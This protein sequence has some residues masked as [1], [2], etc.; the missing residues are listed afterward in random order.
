MSASLASHQQ[1][2][3]ILVVGGSVRFLASSCWRAGWD[4]HAADRFG[5]ADLRAIA[6]SYRPLPAILEAAG[7]PF[8]ELAGVPFLFTGGLENAPDFL[9]R[10]AGSRPSAAAS[11]ASVRAVRDLSRLADEAARVGLRIPET[12]ATPCGLPVDGSF[13]VKPWASVGGQGIARWHG[14]AEPDRPSLWQRVHP[15]TP[16][17]V[18]LVLAESQPPQ[19]LGVCRSLRCLAA[20][21]APG[22]AYAGSVTVP[23]PAWV[24]SIITLAGRLASQHGLRGAVG[25]DCIEDASGRVVVLEVNPR[26]TAS[27]ELHERTQGLCIASSHLAACGI[28]PP[29]LSPQKKP[30]VAAASSKAILYA[31]EAMAITPQVGA[32]LAGLAAAWSPQQDVAA[33]ADLPSADSQ[34]AAGSPLVTVFADGPSSD[35]AEGLLEQRLDQ[36]RAALRQP[37]IRRGIASAAAGERYRI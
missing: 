19:L 24:D 27:M 18:S 35:A 6:A 5:D 31:R 2:P 3:S 21:A 7:D 25:I 28:H 13:L 10:L 36:L 33:I 17:G 12:H 8:P 37:A 14:G 30:A 11:P 34:I 1:R 4:A 23:P 22:C 32:V 29:S 26:P 16:H 9:E 15:G 20:T